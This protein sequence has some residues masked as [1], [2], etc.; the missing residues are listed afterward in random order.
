MRPTRAMFALWRRVRDGTLT[1]G[2]FR[3]QSGPLRAA[4]EDLLLRGYFNHRV[5]GFCKEL[6][7]HREHL[8][9]N[10]VS[11]GRVG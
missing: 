5:R 9:T 10:A 8:W 7:E 4:I 1:R 11:Y 2:Q 6:W 3:D